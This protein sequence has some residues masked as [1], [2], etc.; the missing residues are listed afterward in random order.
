MYYSQSGQDEFL[1]QQV[2]NEKTQGFFLDIGAHDGITISNIYFFEKNRDWKGICVEPNP[3][4]YKKLVHNR[5]SLLENCC[6]GDS[7]REVVF[8]SVSGYAEML[9]GI[10]SMY[11]QRHL[12]RIDREIEERGGSK[13]ELNVQMRTPQS[14]LTQYVREVPEV[15]DYCSIDVE[16]AELD[17]LE[18]MNLTEMA[19]DVFSIE[20]NYKD[21]RLSNFFKGKGYRKIDVIGADLIFRKRKKKFW[22]FV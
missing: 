12:D 21:H 13:R 10:K 6:I 1:D 4:V 9:S 14:L 18:S 8:L 2:F 22:L 7:N 16:G 5:T 15:I 20:D 17:I 11:D 3:V 19:I